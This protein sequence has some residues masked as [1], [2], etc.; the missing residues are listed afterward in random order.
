MTTAQP[1]TVVFP[2]PIHT[3]RNV[4]ATPEGIDIAER[5]F[6]LHLADASR[7]LA[8]ALADGSDPAAVKTARDN[9]TGLAHI[10][11]NHS[12]AGGSWIKRLRA[13]AESGG[14]VRI[15]EG[16]VDRLI[17]SHD[18]VSVELGQ[19]KQ[20]RADINRGIAERR[21]GRHAFTAV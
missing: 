9:A 11:H 19:V 16:F 7:A 12:N 8:R 4:R 10:L 15:D 2:D 17:K 21:P 18:A 3:S 13:A 5:V 1:F 20:L 6:S 14:S